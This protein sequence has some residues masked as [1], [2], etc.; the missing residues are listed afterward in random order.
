[1]KSKIV[2]R[3]AT[4][5]CV[6]VLGVI[7]T[8]SMCWAATGGISAT[9]TASRMSGSYTYG[10]QGHQLKIEIYGYERKGSGE[11]IVK[12]TSVA[13]GSYTSVSAVGTPDAGY[14]F[15]KMSAYGFVDSNLDAAKLNVTI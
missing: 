10:E 14:S 8:G 6:A 11:S 2:K 5:M 1:M 12:R 13:N 7:G 15:Y 3:F 4:F 9:V